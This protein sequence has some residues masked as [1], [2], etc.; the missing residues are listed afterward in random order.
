MPRRWKLS[1]NDLIL[2]WHAHLAHDSRRDARGSLS[3]IKSNDLIDLS[4]VVS[5][6]CNPLVV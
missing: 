2:M 4:L 3:K 5:L 6:E 1:S